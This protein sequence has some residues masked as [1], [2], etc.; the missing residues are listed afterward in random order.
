MNLKEIVFRDDSLP[1]TQDEAVFVV[2]QYIKDRKGKEVD[3]SI[4]THYG[5]GRAM[6]QISLLFEMFF[7]AMFWYRK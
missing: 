3:L 6:N 4:E 1:I 7:T 2:K 5:T